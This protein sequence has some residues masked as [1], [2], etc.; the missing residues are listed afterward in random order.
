SVFANSLWGINLSISVVLG[1]ASVSSLAVVGC[2]KQWDSEFNG[3]DS[4]LS[5]EL[6]VCLL[7]NIVVCVGSSPPDFRDL[8]LVKFLPL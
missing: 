4:F 1:V 3:L 5:K 2:L 7:Q 8:D 6:G